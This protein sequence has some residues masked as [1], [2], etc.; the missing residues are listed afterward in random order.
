M[1]MFTKSLTRELQKHGNSCR[2]DAVK[3][4]SARNNTKWVSPQCSNVAQLY[5]H[6]CTISAQKP[7][8]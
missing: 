1:M 8:S 7:E 3:H 5:P 6:C 4:V 2:E